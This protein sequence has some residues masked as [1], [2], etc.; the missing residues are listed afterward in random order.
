[1]LCLMVQCVI[2]ENRKTVLLLCFS[3]TNKSITVIQSELSEA[4]KKRR[5]EVMVV[6]L[7]L[8]GY[9]IVKTF[10]TS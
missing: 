2:K 10:K 5:I 1:M 7:F 4:I 8:N 9:K 6:Y 3:Q